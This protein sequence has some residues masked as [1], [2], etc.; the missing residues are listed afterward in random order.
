MRLFLFVACGLCSL[1]ACTTPD[2]RDR[3][4]ASARVHDPS[5]PDGDGVK[6][7]QFA[8]IGSV[9]TPDGPIRVV[10]R[11]AVIAGALVPHGL[12]DIMYFDAHGRWITN[13]DHS[14]Y[15]V[16]T[17]WC[18]GPL[19][20][21]AR[22]LPLSENDQPDPDTIATGNA[23]DFSAGLTH[24]RVRAIPAYG[25]W[26]GKHEYSELTGDK[27]IPNPECGVHGHTP[28]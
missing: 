22:G 24:R 25:S 17:L 21:L 23:I 8:Y 13:E 2:L 12:S 18:S 9:T 26:S 6:L 16:R 27:D 19:L 28:N 3:M 15:E 20:I 14:T 1:P 4:L 7:I 11:H 10:E 5:F